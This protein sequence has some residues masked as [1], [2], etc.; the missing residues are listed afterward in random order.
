MPVYVGRTGPAQCVICHQE[1]SRKV[2]E[3][4]YRE[5][6][7]DYFSWNKP[8][9]KI[10][11]IFSAIPLILDP[12]L[13]ALNYLTGSVPSWAWYVFL[14]SLVPPLAGLIWW[15][16]V[17]HGYRQRWK[18]DHP[19]EPLHRHHN[20]P[21]RIALEGALAAFLGLILTYLGLA[22]HGQP[23]SLST[24]LLGWYTILVGGS[25]TFYGRLI[26][27]HPFRSRPFFLAFIGVTITFAGFVAGTALT[28]LGLDCT[29]ITATNPVC[30]LF[31]ILTVLVYIGIIILFAVPV[32]MIYYRLRRPIPHSTNK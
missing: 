8:Y 17:T 2:P 12:I 24:F 5:V 15:A 31:V 29:R 16:K 3:S 22:N 18:L 26:G 19:K 14:A 21:P 4:H 7:P 30:A 28:D 10:L 6:H 25:V 9:Q 11:S 1:Y 32:A 13:L 23:L 27:K 20:S